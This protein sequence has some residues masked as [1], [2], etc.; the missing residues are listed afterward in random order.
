[1][2]KTIFSSLLR[3]RSRTAL[4]EVRPDA[5]VPY[6]SSASIELYLDLM[7]R[8]VTNAIYDDDTDLTTG[9]NRLDE[10]TGKIFPVQGAPADPES[11]FFGGIWP[12]RAHTMIGVPRLDNLQDCVTDVLR[13][14]MPGDLIEAG[15]WRGGATIFMRAILKAYGVTDRL[16]WVADSFEGLPEADAGKHPYDHQL[17]L[18]KAAALAVSLEEVRQNF[19]RYGL[20][21]DQVRFLKGWFRDALPQAPIERLAVLRVDGDHYESTMEAL[22]SLYPLL[23]IGGYVIVDDYHAVEGCDRAVSEF[24]ARHAIA[25]E[26]ILIPGAGAWWQRSR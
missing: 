16:V 21:D 10:A 8:C 4:A 1:M 17:G 7:K 18:H 5:S 12:S 6:G 20:L 15:V 2:L 19:E 24:R 11:K 14:G 26:L 9:I 23:S 3:P 22:S 25:D 13:R